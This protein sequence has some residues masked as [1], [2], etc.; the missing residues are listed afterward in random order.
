MVYCLGN[1]WKI[2]LKPKIYKIIPEK[3]F[4][5]NENFIQGYQMS[6]VKFWTSVPL[7]VLIKIQTRLKSVFFVVWQKCI[8]GQRYYAFSDMKIDYSLV[9]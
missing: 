8:V 7:Y 3:Y 4:N 2:S 5:R 9:I 6:Y 1:I